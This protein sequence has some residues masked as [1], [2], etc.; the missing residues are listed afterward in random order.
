M[1]WTC[2]WVKGLYISMALDGALALSLVCSTRGT[3]TAGDVKNIAKRRLKHKCVESKQVQHCGMLVEN[4]V[5]SSE[6][7]LTGFE[8]WMP[9]ES[10]LQTANQR[11]H[12]AYCRQERW[13][14]DP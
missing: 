6:F 3:E 2:G 8:L 9:L 7:P 10:K 13:V 4:F 11:H 12:G 1:E 5:T 14:E